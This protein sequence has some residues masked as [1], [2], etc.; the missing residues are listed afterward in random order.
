MTSLVWP[1]T[2]MTIQA[3]VP[4]GNDSTIVL[5]GSNDAPLTWHRD[6]TK[7]VVDMPAAGEAAT[8][9]R[10]AFVFRITHGT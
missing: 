10:D 5:L 7:V 8:T 6:G 3:P 9:S 4:I 1:G 2:Q